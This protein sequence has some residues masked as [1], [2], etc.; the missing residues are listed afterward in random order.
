MKKLFQL[1]PNSYTFINYIGLVGLTAFSLLNLA[2]LVVYVKYALG[3]SNQFVLLLPAI[4]L[5]LNIDFL[6]II[7]L[8]LIYNAIEKLFNFK[9][10]LTGILLIG[11]VSFLYIL[12]KNK[13][14]VIITALGLYGLGISL[15]ASI[16]GFGILIPENDI[17]PKTNYDKS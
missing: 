6:F 11:I 7:A 15:Y 2:T 1:T 3:V 4:K 5:L 16:V 14:I 13:P 17:S 12:I 10:F 8:I 9:L